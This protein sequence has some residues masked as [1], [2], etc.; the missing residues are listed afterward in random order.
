MLLITLFFKEKGTIPS[1]Q[2]Y[3]PIFR[4]WP[5]LLIFGGI[6]KRKILYKS[7]NKRPILYH[8]VKLSLGCILFK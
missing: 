5:I 7:N 3:Q 1:F 2:K 6:P 4:F 8:F